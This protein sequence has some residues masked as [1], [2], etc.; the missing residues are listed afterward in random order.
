VDIVPRQ[1]QVGGFGP[2]ARDRADFRANAS[3]DG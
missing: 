3:H 2:P 1:Q